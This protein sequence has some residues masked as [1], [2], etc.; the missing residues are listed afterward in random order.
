MFK[1]IFFPIVCLCIFVSSTAKTTIAEAQIEPMESHGD[2]FDQTLHS[3]LA[4]MGFK[5]EV[6]EYQKVYDSIGY[7]D[8][9]H[10]I[11]K[12]APNAY[13]P[14]TLQR[15]DRKPARILLE[16]TDNE[17]YE[18]A[19]IKVTEKDISNVPYM[20]FDWIARYA[21]S[22]AVKKI[23]STLGLLAKTEDMGGGIY[24]VTIDPALTTVPSRYRFTQIEVYY[25]VEDLFLNVD[26]KVKG[27][28]DYL[29]L[30]FVK[31]EIHGILRALEN[32]H[33]PGSTSAI[34]ASGLLKGSSD[35]LVRD[36]L[37]VEEAGHETLLKLEG[38]PELKVEELEP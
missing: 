27:T 38:N 3:W 6:L 23:S 35:Y 19:H 4:Y 26:I 24:R 10:I 15:A 25:E 11:L 34:L 31:S 14:N 37:K 32:G 17:G 28:K 30:S 9:F 21:I 20:Y 1:K 18:F 22:Y 8:Y 36:L 5:G 13:L 2:N 7:L 12:E 16:T 33:F 29:I